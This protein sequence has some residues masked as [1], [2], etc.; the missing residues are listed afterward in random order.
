MFTA[1]RV[2]LCRTR[3]IVSSIQP[4]HVVRAWTQILSS[5][6]L[7]TR[8]RTPILGRPNGDIPSDVLGPF[9]MLQILTGTNSPRTV[10]DQRNF[11]IGILLTDA[12]NLVANEMSISDNVGPFEV[13][14][15]SV[16][17]AGLQVRL[18]FPVRQRAHRLPG[19]NKDNRART[20]TM[21]VV[22]RGKNVRRIPRISGWRN[23]HTTHSSTRDSSSRDR[24]FHCFR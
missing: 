5:A 2:I 17:P 9:L 16:I 8:A 11:C 18:H 13:K 7:H 14:N 20:L 12:I 15:A 4:V 1:N 10:P 6:T 21:H 24:S 22:R 19:K 23:K 3:S